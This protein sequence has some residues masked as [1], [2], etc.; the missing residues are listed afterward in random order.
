MI[1]LYIRWIYIYIPQ[2]LFIF[3][4]LV[5]HLVVNFPLCFCC[6]GFNFESFSLFHYM[7]SLSVCLSVCL[8]CVKH[9]L[10]TY[11]LSL[12]LSPS[13]LLPSSISVSLS[14][15][16]IFLSFVRLF[17]F[18]SSLSLGLPDS[19]H[20]GAS[21]AQH[22][23]KEQDPRQTGGH[24]CIH[25]HLVWHQIQIDGRSLASCSPSSSSDSRGVNFVMSL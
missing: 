16:L 15:S 24:V 14:F 21:C 9:Q 6:P 25:A 17:S 13:I 12:S 10:R 23:T 18:P 19:L 5:F 3:L 8:L 11:C 20:N 4:V 2:N 22:K 7:H 1:L